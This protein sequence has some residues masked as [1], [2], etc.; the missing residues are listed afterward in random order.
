M[1]GR[2]R[3]LIFGLKCIAILAREFTA[4]CGV[5]GSQVFFEAGKPN[6][7]NHFNQLS[8]EIFYIFNHSKLLIRESNVFLVDII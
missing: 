1:V 5:S 2:K 4:G 8:L 3:L 6:I 7:I